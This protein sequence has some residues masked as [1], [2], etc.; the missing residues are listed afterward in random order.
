MLAYS[1]ACERNKQ[2][3]LE[4]L[5]DTLVGH[6]LVLEIGSGTGQHAVYFAAH[7][8]HLTWLPTDIPAALPPLQARIDLEGTDN[9]RLPV[10]LDVARS[11]WNVP[12]VDAVFTAN[13]LHIISW[14]L[15][16]DCFAGIGRHLEPGGVLCVYGPFRY[17]GAYTTD[18]NARFDVS[19][20]LQDPLMGIRDFEAVDRLAEAQGL[21]LLADHAMP[22]NNQLLVW[23]RH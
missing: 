18:S 14:D 17:R 21:S 19:L 2:P 3:I 9:I 13:T 6:Q 15:I 5:Q 7:L 4:I 23:Q 12:K 11:A 1:G 22:A 20:K 16:V 8:D 10:A